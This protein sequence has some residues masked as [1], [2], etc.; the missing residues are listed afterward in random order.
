MK[1]Y[2]LKRKLQIS[3]ENFKGRRSRIRYDTAR[4]LEKFAAGICN[5]QLKDIFS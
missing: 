2:V 3:S 4:R 1:K 5:L